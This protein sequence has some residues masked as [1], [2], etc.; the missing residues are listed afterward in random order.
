[1]KVAF[2][3]YCNSHRSHRLKMDSANATRAIVSAVLDGL[4]G[5]APIHQKFADF[6]S[7]KLNIFNYRQQV[8]C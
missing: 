4:W 8:R 3:W 6:C 1:M 2:D 7:D 5:V